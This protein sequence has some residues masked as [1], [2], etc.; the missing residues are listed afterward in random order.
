[1]TDES[2]RARAVV[3]AP[4]DRGRRERAARETLV[5]VDVGGVEQREVVHRGE[6]AG[7][8]PVVELRPAARSGSTVVPEDDAPVFTA[9]GQVDVA[10]VPLALVE[11][12]HEGDRL[13]TLS[14]DLL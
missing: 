7:D 2:D 6:D 9:Q 4:R 12:G 13:P 5:G 11:L 1:M 14:G 10:G 3:E 8:E